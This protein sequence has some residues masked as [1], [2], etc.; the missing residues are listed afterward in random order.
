[1]NAVTPTVT[2]LQ[3]KVALVTGGSR[4]NGKAT[5]LALARAGALVAVNYRTRAQEAEAVC[6]EIARL[7]GK[8]IVPQADVSIAA[9]VQRMV[10]QVEEQLG[11]IA[12]L[13]NNAG[14]SR[15]QRL[16][17]RPD[18]QRQWWVVHELRA[19]RQSAAATY[20]TWVSK[21]TTWRT[22]SSD[23]LAQ[24]QSCNAE[25]PLQVYSRWHTSV[26]PRSVEGRL[27]AVPLSQ[28]H[29]GL[30]WLGHVQVHHFAGHR[31]YPNKPEHVL[32]GEADIEGPRAL[33]P[34]FYGSFDWHSSVHGH[35]MLVRLLRLFP[36]LPESRAWC[37]RG[38]SAT[39]STDD[40]A[41][42]VL[43]E[44][45]ARHAEAA[46]D[47]VASGEYAGEHWLA[48]FAVYLLSQP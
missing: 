11:P 17:H 42:T 41:R 28:V 38:I 36:D 44:S 13:V 7:G 8:A 25:C 32:N 39:L 9:E 31:G 4:G 26:H 12:V 24:F 34:A 20:G 23:I 37:M 16:H 21:P 14:I 2:P 35:W 22:D 18:D 5:A 45:A 10:R 46:L 29:G 48:S 19:G 27:H 6:A 33:H 43:A 47:H 1:V 30:V 40:P 3:D 15:L